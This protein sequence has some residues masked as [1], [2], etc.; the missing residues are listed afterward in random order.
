MKD[1]AT[2]LAS[3]LVVLTFGFFYVVGQQLFFSDQLS[4]SGG[5]K[6]LLVDE[7]EPTVT[8]EQ[9]LS[10]SGDSGNQNP[11]LSEIPE[12][13]FK[14][15][16]RN[17]SYL[18]QKEKTLLFTMKANDDDDPNLTFAI[19]TQPSHGHLGVIQSLGREARVPYTPEAGFKGTDSFTFRVTDSDGNT[20]RGTITLKVLPELIFW[21][22][23]NV[24]DW[25]ASEFY[26]E[27]DGATA[28]MD[29]LDF[30]MEAL[31]DI[32]KVSHRTIFTTR[33]EYAYT[34]FYNEVNDRKPPGLEIIGGIKT[35]S[36]MPLP[37]SPAT[38]GTPLYDFANAA[39][40]QTIASAAIAIAEDTGNKQIVLENETNLTGYNFDYYPID[41]QALALA[42]QPLAAAANNQDIEFWWW[43]P[44][45][46]PDYAPNDGRDRIAWTRALVEVV[47]NNVPNS[48]FI[49]GTAA[50]YWWNDL[51]E[52]ARNLTVD[53]VGLDN[54][55]EDLWVMHDWGPAPDPETCGWDA[56]EPD[57]A[58]AGCLRAYSTSEALQQ[59]E[60]YFPRW[61]GDN[62]TQQLLGNK[63][64]IYP[65]SGGEDWIESAKEFSQQLPPVGLPTDYLSDINS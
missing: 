22:E 41:Y 60:S 65:A 34:N 29:V 33:H 55:V 58:Y 38:G 15:R 2:L 50:R 56:P 16:A 37:I 35:L 28:E 3:L 9:R 46:L 14:P 40:W 1:K 27:E 8:I 6:L 53:F 13:D 64:I 57:G 45:I 47:K 43:L 52:N 21:K 42:L 61:V 59:L 62:N 54:V 18:A 51:D 44:E 31:P 30:A 25:P 63:T 4:R 24:P 36:A 12:P 32:A 23:V 48:K 49:L 11:P 17:S 7:V 26:T 10:A 20:D 39:A 5:A 19:S